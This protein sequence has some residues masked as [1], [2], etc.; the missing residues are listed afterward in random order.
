MS[1]PLSPLLQPNEKIIVWN[2]LYRQ[3]RQ[4]QVIQRAERSRPLQRRDDPTEQ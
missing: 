4:V 3:I 1:A 2:E